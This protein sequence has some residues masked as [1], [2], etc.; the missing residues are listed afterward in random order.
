[1]ELERHSANSN[2]TDK[3]QFFKK[4]IESPTQIGSI[5]PSSRFLAN[6]MLRPI[7]WANARFIAELGAGT[8]VFT[9]H[10]QMNKHCNCEVA[11][12]EKDDDMRNRL[13]NTYPELKFCKDAIRL[14]EEVQ[15][16]GID[17]LEAV[18][19][20]LPFAL[21]KEEVREQIID[22]VL[23]ALK[24][25]GIFVAFQYSLQ[26]KK[27]LSSKFSKVEIFFEPLNLPP[28]FVYVCFK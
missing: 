7:D 10:I 23:Q 8:G 26:M 28:A 25:N 13:N 11:V 9:K 4:F 12:F 3:K 6:K 14:S 16:M 18:V 20:G 2:Y 27:M 22:E 1:M 24:P 5:V 21:F 15:S 17:S 19:S